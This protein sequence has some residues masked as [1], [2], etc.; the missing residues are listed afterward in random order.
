MH[1][2]QV[3]VTGGSGFLGAH[4]I[5][6][7]L[8]AGYCVRATVRSLSLESEV[9]D[10]VA[11]GGA[12]AGDRLA[13]SCADLTSDT[14]WPE[15]VDC[16]EYVLHVASP[17]PAADPENEDDVIVPAREG[18]LRVLKASRDAGVKRIVVTGSYVAVGYGHRPVDREFTE[19]DWTNVDTP[20]VNAYVKSKLLAERAAW[21]FINAEATY[22]ELTVINPGGIFGPIL[23]KDLSTSIKLIQALITHGPDA[24]PNV[25]VPVVDIRD[26]ADLHITAMTHPAAPGEVASQGRCKSGLT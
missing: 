21:D 11:A 19:D 9:R 15:A 18:T 14:G 8:N 26:V 3:L 23:G 13:F 4:F 20:D 6:A 17:F 12:D 25:A 7:L 16:C 24:V 5:V 1:S 22:T 10:M 2:D